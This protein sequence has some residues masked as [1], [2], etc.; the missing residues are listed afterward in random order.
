[1]DVKRSIML[2]CVIEDETVLPY[3]FETYGS[4]VNLTLEHIEKIYNS[5]IK[6]EPIEK[7]CSI[8]RQKKRI[9]YSNENRDKICTAC[10][11]KTWS[12]FTLFKTFKPKLVEISKLNNK[13]LTHSGY[14]YGSISTGVKIF[15]SYLSKHNKREN[16][17]N[18]GKELYL[19][20]DGKIT[21]LENNIK[22]TKSEIRRGAYKTKELAK[23]ENEKVKLQKELK[24]YR[25]K[26]ERKH[27]Q[28][29][30]FKNNEIYFG[31]QGMFEFRQSN[32]GYN[33]LFSDYK[34][35]RSKIQMKLLIGNLNKL[36]KVCK[37]KVQLKNGLYHC[38]KC[39]T[40]VPRQECKINF[41]EQFIQQCIEK[42]QHK[43]VYPKL[44]R[45]CGI[46]YFIFP[47]RNDV[48]IKSREEIEEWIKKDKKI[49]YCCLSFGIKKPIN[50]VVIKEGKIKTIKSFGDGSLYHKGEVERMIRAKIFNDIAER[51]KHDHPHKENDKKLHWKKRN[52]LKKANDK[53]GFRHIRF[54][55]Y[56][57][58]KLTHDITKYIK[59]HC[60]KPLILFRDNSNIKDISYKGNLM[61][62]LS[63][64]SVQQQSTFLEYKAYLNDIPIYKICYKDLKSLSCWKCK[65]ESKEKFTTQILTHE[66]DFSCN[67]CGVHYNFNVVG[68]YNL[69]LKLNEVCKVG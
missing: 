68:G 44:I 34:A 43:I 5:Y 53:M 45:R 7:E 6:I 46:Y 21:A 38:P 24:D 48:D 3:L 55:N 60:E 62:T 11:M 35:L 1:M 29:P 66:T 17:I 52:A 8:C 18:K 57:N 50:L 41:Q 10:F 25:K 37:T 9:T 64:W 59:D 19:I 69:Y 28:F 63:R 51:Y 15:K 31:K 67:E 47:T 4:F 30:I 36:H 26:A 23:M 42:R 39:G 49:E 16:E 32:D 20:T 65:N 13:F 27:I 56:Y 61:R 54:T 33:L 2:K 22:K 14:Y 12:E 40:I 58:H